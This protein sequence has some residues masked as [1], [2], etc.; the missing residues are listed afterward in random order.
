MNTLALQGQVLARR[1]KGHKWV[2]VASGTH[3]APIYQFFP[4]TRI[5]YS[6]ITPRDYHS[7]V[8]YI[9]RVMKI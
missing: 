5:R 2:N 9:V 4:E 8:Y 7:A 3:F 6:R 1:Q